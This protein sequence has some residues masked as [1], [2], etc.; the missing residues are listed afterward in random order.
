MKQH[1]SP[2]SATGWHWATIT[3]HNHC[4]TRKDKKKKQ[5][6]EQKSRVSVTPG[7]TLARIYDFPS[8]LREVFI[9]LNFPHFSFQKALNQG[10]LT[11]TT[12]EWTFCANASIVKVFG[13][14]QHSHGI[15]IPGITAYSWHQSS[16]LWLQVPLWILS[17]QCR[18]QIRYRTY[19]VFNTHLE[20]HLLLP[21][22]IYIQPRRPTSKNPAQTNAEGEPSF[23]PSHLIVATAYRIVELGQG[24]IILVAMEG[25]NCHDCTDAPP[26]W[27]M[28]VESED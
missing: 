27:R 9:A 14:L 16:C 12:I 25:W 4:T 13:L 17:L 10:T 21:F 2:K 23:A 28:P 22:S 26:A 7:S 6:K 5:R 18:S 19:I 8:H 24:H 11:G 20:A 15:F 3:V 1:E